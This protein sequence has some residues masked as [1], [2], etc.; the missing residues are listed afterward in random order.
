MGYAT[1]DFNQYSDNMEP[2]FETIVEHV[3][4]P[5]V[6]SNGPFQM[7][8]STLDYSSYVGMIGIGR[9]TRGQVKTNMPVTIIDTRRQNPFMAEFC[10][11]WDIWVWIVAKYR[12]PMQVISLRSQVLMN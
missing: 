2:L 5:N 3:P 7:Q 1:L 8:I 9:I 12:L 11:C 6:E 10:K 4:P